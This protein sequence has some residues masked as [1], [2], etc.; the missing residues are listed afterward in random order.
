[1]NKLKLSYLQKIKIKG[2]GNSMTVQIFLNLQNHPS[3]HS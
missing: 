2:Y 3:P 1:M